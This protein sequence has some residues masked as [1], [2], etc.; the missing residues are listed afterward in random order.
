MSAITKIARRLPQGVVTTM[1][2]VGVLM[3]TGSG[4]QKS[5]W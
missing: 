1:L 3:G 4:N 5:V 2:S